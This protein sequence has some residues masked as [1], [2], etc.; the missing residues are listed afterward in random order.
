MDDYDRWKLET[1]IGVI[2]RE[3]DLLRQRVDDLLIL[4]QMMEPAIA[5]AVAHTWKPEDYVEFNRLRRES[6]LKET[7]EK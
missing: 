4:L 3:R 5:F 2:E 1:R 7:G 6:G